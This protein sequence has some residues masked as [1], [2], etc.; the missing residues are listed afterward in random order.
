MSKAPRTLVS[1]SARLCA[2][3]MASESGEVIRRYFGTSFLIEEKA[4]LTPVTAADRAAEKVMR[5]IVKK[6]FP[7]HGFIGE[8]EGADRGDAEFVWV[9]D[10][11]DGTK[12]FIAGSYD[13]GTVIALLHAGEPILG[14]IHQPVVGS[15]LI[16]DASTC[17]HNDVAV[18]VRPCARLADAVLLT[19]DL[20][21]VHKFQSDSGFKDLVA[22]TRFTRT[23][24]NCFGYSLVARGL[25][26]IMIDP[27]MAPWDLLG[28][29]PIVRGAGGV[30]T[31]YQG[32]D[33]VKSNSIVA[34][35]PEIHSEVIAM[36]N[37]GLE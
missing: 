25:A 33:P 19:T 24:G 34:T 11:I 3:R 18:R 27:I 4:D 20:L 15:L 2:K 9:V 29:I 10:P 8:E 6:T 21:N 14:V 1:E 23:W 35:V 7:D 5:E 32:R 30:I 17:T 22:R 28:L 12:S 31:D 13:F 36:L 16:G 37:S 26:D